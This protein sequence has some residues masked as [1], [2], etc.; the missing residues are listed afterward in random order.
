MSNKIYTVVLVVLLLVIS[1]VSSTMIQV[2]TIQ[3][4][5]N[6]YKDMR[7]K[8]PHYSFVRT[9]TM[10]RPNFDS[11]LNRNLDLIETSTKEGEQSEQNADTKETFMISVAV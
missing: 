11:T 4:R 1:T 2:S 9:L 8:R 7:R 3:T 6:S 5:L 10:R